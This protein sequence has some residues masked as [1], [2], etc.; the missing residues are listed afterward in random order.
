MIHSCVTAVSNIRLDFNRPQK[1][2]FNHKQKRSETDKFAIFWDYF[3]LTHQYTRYLSGNASSATAWRKKRKLVLKLPLSSY[4]NQLIEE[5]NMKIIKYLGVALVLLL[6]SC[7]PYVNVSTDYD[8]A[9]N[10]QQYRSFNWYRSKA[11]ATKQDSMQYDTFFD[12][13]MQNAIKANLGQRNLEFN[14]NPDFYVNYNV[15]FSNQV[16][17]NN[18]PFYPYG[19]WGGYSRFSNSNQ[20]K[21]G[22]VIVDLIDAKTNQLIWRGVGESEV[23]NRNIPEDKV[24]EIVNGILSKFP[25]KR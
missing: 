24:M 16:A 13:R 11:T 7:A 17:S 19:Y 20:Y 18:G 4:I 10:F 14:A 8:H 23:R 15:T 2:Q 21:E 3:T 12:K 5:S 9:V 22:T 25:P 1:W 6:A